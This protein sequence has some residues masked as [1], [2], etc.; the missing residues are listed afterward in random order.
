MTQL[1][2]IEDRLSDID[3]RTRAIE[4]R[5]GELKGEEA[6]HHWLGGFM[7]NALTIIIAA[8]AGLAGSHAPLGGH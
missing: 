7:K 6:G 8:V 3:A 5:L 2:R 4:I 1:D